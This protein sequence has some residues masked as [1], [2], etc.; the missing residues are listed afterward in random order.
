MYQATREDIKWLKQ[1]GQENEVVSELIKNGAQPTLTMIG[2]YSAPS[3]NW[4]YQIGI[5]RIGTEF[6]EL[7]TQFGQVK[8]GREIYMPS[9]D[10]LENERGTDEK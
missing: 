4:A 6:Y 1:W 10:I 9:Y 5:V 2:Y 3:W 8:G 7:L